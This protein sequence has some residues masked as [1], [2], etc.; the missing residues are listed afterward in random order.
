VLPGGPAYPDHVPGAFSNEKTKQN[1]CIPPGRAPQ[2][3]LEL[4]RKITAFMGPAED[5][6]TAIPGV[7]I[8]RRIAPTPPCRT[9]YH[10]GVI[11][12]AQGRSK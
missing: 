7:S 6:A 12:I 5:K 9:T 11:V 2:L 8:H 4:A 1:P 3:G 10:P